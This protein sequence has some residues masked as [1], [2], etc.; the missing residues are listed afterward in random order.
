MSL[1]IDKGIEKEHYLNIC[2]EL[3]SIFLILL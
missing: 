2:T 1:C 3:L